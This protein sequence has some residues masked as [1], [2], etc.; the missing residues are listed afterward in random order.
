MLTIQ[1]DPQ[2]P[3]PSRGFRP[4]ISP[5]RAE[6]DVNL[7]AIQT[8]AMGLTYA[9]ECFGLRARFSKVGIAVALA[10]VAS[11]TEKGPRGPF[12]RLGMEVFKAAWAQS[13][14]GGC[15]WWRRWSKFLAK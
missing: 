4:A 2:R 6:D 8:T 11:M 12:A 7:L 9:A 5:P 10:A 1:T 13:A 3:S 14:C 15:D